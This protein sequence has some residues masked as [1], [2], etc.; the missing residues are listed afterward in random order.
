[1]GF[2][3]CSIMSRIQSCPLRQASS[4]EN[5][6]KLYTNNVDFSK[7]FTMYVLFAKNHYFIISGEAGE[8]APYVQG[9]DE[10]AGVVD[11][12]KRQAAHS[13]HAELGMFSFK[14]DTD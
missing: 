4:T 8:R 10:R 7:I 12:W 13:T 6:L 14:C 1:M 9:R 11:E 5:T 3:I 2:F